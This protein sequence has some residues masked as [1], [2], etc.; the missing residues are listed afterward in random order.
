MSVSRDSSYRFVLAELH[1]RIVPACDWSFTAGIV[2]A[3]FVEPLPPPYPDEADAQALQEEYA[4]W[5]TVAGYE[6][7]VSE[8]QG[9]VMAFHKQWQNAGLPAA[10]SSLG[11]TSEL[12]EWGLAL[13][14]QEEE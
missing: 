6:E 5:R 14:F 9:R 8:W 10:A 3:P 7:R 13:V 2:R 4:L 11:P 1:R 12:T